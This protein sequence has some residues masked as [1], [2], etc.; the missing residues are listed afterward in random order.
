MP[1]IGGKNLWVLIRRF[2][3]MLNM[4][5]IG[6]DQLA[7]FLRVNGLKVRWSKKRT[8]KTTYSGHRY[9]V[10]PNIAKELEVTKPNQLWVADITHI[11]I[12]GSAA[13]LF[14]ITDK[15]S[16]TIVGH[17]LARSLHA[18]G[19]IEALNRALAEHG[20]PSGVVHHSDRG[21]QYC[22]HDFLD[23]IRRFKLRSSMTDADH[24]AQNALAECMNGIM[25]REFLLDL[26]FPSFE[27]AHQA[28]DD[29]VWTYNNLR[30]HGALNGKTPMEVH[31]GLDSAA[32]KLWLSEI[33]AFEAHLP[34]DKLFGV[35]SI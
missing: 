20:F 5:L 23:E 34:K 16:K 9:A 2:Q 7:A 3:R 12:K 19:A 14:L 6:R 27:Y 8:I 25:K 13:Y 31:T 10:Q 4:R 32:L 28:V 33:V 11:S 26:G 29:A 1:Q 17:F 35:N 24:C 21:V 30:L 18:S 15:C 22:C